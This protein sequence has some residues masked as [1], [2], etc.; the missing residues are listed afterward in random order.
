MEPL[1]ST[2]W[3]ADAL[4]APDLRVIDASW[5]LPEQGRDGT[6]EFAQAHIPGAVFFDLAKISDRSNPLPHMLPPPDQFA[7]A[8]G[9]LG[10]SDRDG[11]VVYDDSP[12]RTAARAWWM[13]R[14]MGARDVAILDG[15]FGKW[16]AEGR[17]VE[18]GEARAEPAT[19]RVLGDASRALDLGEMRAAVAHR[20]QIVDARSPTRFRGEEPEPRAGVQPGHIPGSINLHYARLFNPDGTYKDGAALAAEFDAADVEI[21]HPIVATCGSGVTAA[22]LVFALHLLGQDASLYD[23]SWSDWGSAPD[24]PKELGA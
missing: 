8:M 6:A 2:E 12:S 23:G 24:T 17:P 9:A 14:T 18:A 21:D 1:V 15:G 16:R 4:G 3:L 11:I 13:L 20:D 5:F 19:F 22:T 7:E 10:V